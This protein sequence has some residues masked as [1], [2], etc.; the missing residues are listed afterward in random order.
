MSLIQ[1]F[2]AV[3]CMNY[4]LKNAFRKINLSLIYQNGLKRRGFTCRYICPFSQEET[5]LTHPVY[6]YI[7]PFNKI[8]PKLD[9]FSYGTSLD[10]LIVAKIGEIICRYVET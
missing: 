9:L 8:T 10:C 6:F 2:Q 1:Q 3:S 7:K 4:M 5:S